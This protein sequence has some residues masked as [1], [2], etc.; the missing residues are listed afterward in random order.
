MLGGNLT[1]VGQNIFH[2]GNY[3]THIDATAL[4]SNIP[5]T[6]DDAFDGINPADIKLKVSDDSLDAWKTHPAWGQFNIY[7]EGTTGVENPDLTDA[8]DGIKIALNKSEISIQ[9]SDLIESVQLWDVAGALK[10]YLTPSENSVSIPV[11]ELPSGIMVLTVKT[12]NNKK[13]VKLII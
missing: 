10:I 1:S 6:H 9:S 3:L 12:T 13:S 5:D 4:E 2:G 11:S 8:G 7:S